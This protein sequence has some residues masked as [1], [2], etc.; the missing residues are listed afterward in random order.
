MKNIVLFLLVLV[1]LP[2]EI[3][4]QSKKDSIKKINNMLYT[5]Q[6]CDF[7]QSLNKNSIK[8][9]ERLH[10]S[11]RLHFTS[12]YLESQEN[13]KQATKIDWKKV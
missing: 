6:S 2:W 8:I 9:I 4:G 13:F 12:K 7:G 3:M 11:Q 10:F 1:I 5:L